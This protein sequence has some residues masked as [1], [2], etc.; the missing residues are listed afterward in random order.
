[1]WLAPI[2]THMDDTV[3]VLLQP[4]MVANKKSRIQP[5]T[6]SNDVLTVGIACA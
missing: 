1:M 6:F 2:N 5:P 3:H 4:A